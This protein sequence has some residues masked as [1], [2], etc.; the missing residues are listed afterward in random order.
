MQIK[1]K[2]LPQDKFMKIKFNQ[3]S[4]DNPFSVVDE[5]KLNN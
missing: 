4:K 1:E 3:V 5:D 2:E